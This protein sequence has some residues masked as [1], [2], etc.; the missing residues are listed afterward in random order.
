MFYTSGD[1]NP[2]DGR[3]NGFDSV[4]DLPNFAGGL[5][6][7]WNL[8]AIRLTGSAVSLKSDG[9][10]IPAL[11]SSKEEGQ[12]NFVNPGIFLANA[13]ADFDITPKLKGFVNFNYLRFMRTESLEDILFQY[14]IH[15]PIGEDL[16]VGVEYR[17]PLSENIVLMGGASALQP[18][19]GFRDIY[20]SRTL[21][22]LF[23]SVKFTF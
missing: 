7:F 17:P 3:A 18:G 21:F 14:P 6:S 23:G 10:L 20:S 19:Q 12:A 5:F 1:A 13:G 2:R 11:R 15:H 4:V 9:S 22:S 8:E 16:G